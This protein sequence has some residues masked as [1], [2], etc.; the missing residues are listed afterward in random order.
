MT[1]VS[2]TQTIPVSK[3]GSISLSQIRDML[4]GL[5]FAILMVGIQILGFV[6]GG[7]SLQ[8]LHMG[9]IGYLGVFPSA[10]GLLGMVKNEAQAEYKTM[11]DCFSNAVWTFS[12]SR[13]AEHRHTN[14]PPH[15]TLVVARPS[16]IGSNEK[17]RAVLT[18]N[19]TVSTCASY[20]VFYLGLRVS[21]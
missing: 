14:A 16:T 20:A 8:A 13:H 6:Q 2:P 12:D 9:L 10:F 3:V 21:P 11:P 5:T 18:L 17:R 4:A 7:S 19:L 1:G 15:N